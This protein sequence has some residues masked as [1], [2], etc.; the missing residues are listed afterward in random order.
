MDPSSS[1]REVFKSGPVRQKHRSALKNAPRIAADIVVPR[2]LYHTTVMQDGSNTS[3]QVE[4]IELTAE[5]ADVLA[6]VH[7]VGHK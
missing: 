4:A 2:P 6:D 5:M 7:T 3:P 1:I